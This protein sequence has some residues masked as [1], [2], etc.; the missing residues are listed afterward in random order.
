MRLTMIRFK[1][2]HLEKKRK[3]EV[4]LYYGIKKKGKSSHQWKR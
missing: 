1:G 2:F 3:N 4:R